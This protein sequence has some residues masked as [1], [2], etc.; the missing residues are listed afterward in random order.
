MG[1]VDQSNSVFLAGISKQL[2]E[3]VIITNHPVSSNWRIHPSLTK[4]GE[5][6]RLVPTDFEQKTDDK[7]K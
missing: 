6:G 7:I 2:M 5:R 3:E 4:G 1:M